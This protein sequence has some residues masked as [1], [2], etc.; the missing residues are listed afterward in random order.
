MIWGLE[1]QQPELAGKVCRTAFEN[2]L[3]IETSGAKTKS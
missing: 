3:M 2:G 1:F